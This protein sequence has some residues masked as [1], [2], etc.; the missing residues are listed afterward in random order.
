[1]KK[2]ILFFCFLIIVKA[3][4]QKYELGKVTKDELEEKVHPN[5]SS[6]PAAILLKKAKT[7][8]IYSDKKGF[9][10]K[11]EFSIKIKIYK[12]EGLKWANFEIPYYVGYETLDKEAV[13]ILKA[14][15][16]NLVNGKIE[17]E[18]VSSEGKFKEKINEFWET[19]LITFPNVKEGSIIELSY[20]LNT[21]N[22]SEL[23]GFQFQYKI[24]VNYAQYITEIPAFYIYKGI[25]IG[26]IDININDVLEN[27]SQ[28]YVNQYQ[29][30]NY[31][32]YQQIKTIYDVSNV[33][34]LKEEDYVSNI[35]NFYGKIE[36]ELQIIRFPNEEPKQIATTWESVA[37][38]IY[39]EKDFGDELSKNGYFLSD[40]KKM[41]D[42]IVSKEDRLKAIYE[43]VKEKMT[44]NGKFG[45]YT[46][47]GVELAYKETS[48][49]VAEIN[50]ILTSMLKM[51]GLD[52]SPVLLSTRD[53]GVPLF[54][55]RSKFNYVI[56]TV[57]L[58]GKQ[59]LLDATDK[60]C[61][62]GNLPI[63]DL[64]DKG[65]QI[66]KDG[67]SVEINL[68]PNFISLYNMNFFANIDANGDVS[69]QVREQYF[70]YNGLRFRENYS[71]IAKDSYIEKLE[72]A[73]PGLEVENYE[74]RNDK[75]VEE[76]IIE[77]YFIKN[78]NVIEKIGDKMFFSPKLYLASQLNPFKQENRQYPV[79]FAF[80]YK[81]KYA[82]VITIP[83]GYQVESLPKPMALS[84][85]NK[86]AAFNFLISTLENKITIAINLEINTAVLPSNQYEVLKEFFKKVIEKENE[87]IVLKKI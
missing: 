43:F 34:A 82:F 80:P 79:D 60:F 24:P 51:G 8:F 16:Y 11:T 54:P 73:H 77:S 69:G 12:K 3:S 47:K 10:S 85:D 26:Y 29:Q 28:G 68:M 39:E 83:D 64:N 63:R 23:P 65:R 20:E 66:N 2:V 78:K 33:P 27:T 31:L 74:L 41:T 32:N 84:I 75:I 14:Y 4:A 37:K 35:N 22:L 25:K 61:S 19:K 50:I 13:V 71:S 30:T 67:S 6:A 9:E 57:N 70:G 55:N 87:K 58:E 44:W 81:D 21:Q 59:I 52:A 62:I 7:R 48:G 49:N 56:V 46:K 40:L 53:N 86:Y 18:K 38:S 42:K 36:H 17:R 5:D 76:P 15:T 72:K 45:Y 1:M